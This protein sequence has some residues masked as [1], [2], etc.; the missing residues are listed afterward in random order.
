MQTFW[1]WVVKLTVCTV[2]ER[3]AFIEIFPQHP[4]IFIL[5]SVSVSLVFTTTP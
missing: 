5:V 1:G 2:K 3:E 4:F